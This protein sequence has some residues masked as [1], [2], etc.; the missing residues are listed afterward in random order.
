MRAIGAI[1]RVRESSCCCYRVSSAKYNPAFTSQL[2]AS[3]ASRA[4]ASWEQR[5]LRRGRGSAC[6][7][8][9]NEGDTR[10]RRRC[11]PPRRLPAALGAG[12]A[13]RRC[14]RATAGKSRVPTG[15][16]GGPGAGQSETCRL[17]LLKA[18]LRLLHVAD[19]VRVAAGTALPFAIC[20]LLLGKRSFLSLLSIPPRKQLAAPRLTRGAAPHS[21][22]RRCPDL[23]SC[24][25]PSS[26]RD[27]AP[28]TR[29]TH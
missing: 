18:A 13:R 3:S 15:A 27:A 1:A 2:I 4:L 6:S 24:P 22:P 10:P 9:G 7:G 21:T 8:Y 14:P 17:A 20:V 25:D 11:P 16:A 26:P 23:G 5:V 29:V 19:P 28:A 12:S